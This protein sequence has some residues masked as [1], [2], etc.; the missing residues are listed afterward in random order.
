[1]LDVQSLD[2]TYGGLR[3]VVDVSLHVAEGEMVAVIGPNG[4]GKS[5]LFNAI[6]GTAPVTGGRVMFE[7]ADLRAMKPHERARRGIAHVPEGRQVFASMTVRENIEVGSQ[8]QPD[9]TRRR[10]A[11]DQVYAL[12]PILAERSTQLAGMLSGGQQQMLAIGRGLASG[13][14][15]LMLDEPSMGLAPAIVEQ[16]FDRIAEARRVGRLTV[17]LAEQRAIEAIEA[18]DHGVVMQSGR[19]ALAGSRDTLLDDPQIRSLYLGL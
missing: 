7:G 8:I 14:R 16:I 2:V 1:V 13:P 11:I 4:A 15:L 19:V 17:L 5:S 9:V 12:F 3:A 10:Q 18:C 6:S